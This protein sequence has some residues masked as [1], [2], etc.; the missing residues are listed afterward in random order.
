MGLLLHL[1]PG[2]CKRWMQ[3]IRKDAFLR[4]V[5]RS[6]SLRGGYR[7]VL[8]GDICTRDYHVTVPLQTHMNAS[9]LYFAGDCSRGIQVSKWVAFFLWKGVDSFDA[10]KFGRGKLCESVFRLDLLFLYYFYLLVRSSFLERHR[11][12]DLGDCL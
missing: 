9:M 1:R 6:K 5:H 10:G 3:W 2:P 12:C 4:W 8:I 11:F 7:A